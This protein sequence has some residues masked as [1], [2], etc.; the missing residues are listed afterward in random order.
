MPL[1][2]TLGVLLAAQQRGL[3]TDL[4]PSIAAL[5][6]AGLYFQPSLISRVLDLARGN[7]SR[8]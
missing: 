3:I 7:G 2:G 5:Q 1:T 8:T 6:A 4:Q